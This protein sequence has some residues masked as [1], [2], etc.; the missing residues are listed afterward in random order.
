MNF[1]SD[2]TH[3]AFRVQDGICAADVHVDGGEYNSMTHLERCCEVNLFPK[4]GLVGLVP[5]GFCS[6]IFSPPRWG[7]TLDR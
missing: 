2:Q 1:V 7:Q 6:V 4:S 3:A 5:V